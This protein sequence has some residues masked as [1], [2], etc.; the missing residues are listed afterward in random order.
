MS[1]KSKFSSCSRVILFHQIRF[2]SV[3]K[4]VQVFTCKDINKAKIKKLQIS[5]YMTFTKTMSFQQ[6]T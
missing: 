3:R 1:S 6:L 4:E 5:F 2:N